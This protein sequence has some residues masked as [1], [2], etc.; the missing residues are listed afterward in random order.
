MRRVP[1]FLFPLLFVLPFAV[2]LAACDCNDG[3]TPTGACETS[4]DCED[5]QICVDMMCEAAPDGSTDTGTTDGGMDTGMPPC[6][7]DTDCGGGVC[8]GGS[9][10]PS[11]DLVCGSG[12][13][14]SGETCFANACVMPGGS[15]RSSEDCGD[16]QYCE[17]GLADPPMMGMDGGTPDAGMGD[18]GVCLGGA[19]TVGRCLDIPPR[20]A[21]GMPPGP[22]EVC[23]RD[24]EYR[25]P[26]GM[27]DAV[28]QWAF[29]STT[30]ETYTGR[31][32]V[33]STPTVGRVADTNC[34]GVVDEFDPPNVIFI[35]GNANGSY[36]SSSVNTNACK[37]GVIRALDGP[38]G[39]EL[40]SLRRPVMSSLG[41]AALS[42][43]IGDLD[44]DGDMEVVAID[45]EGYFNIVDHTGAHVA[46]SDSPIPAFASNNGTGWGGAVTIGDMDQDGNPELAYGRA[47][48]TTDGTSIT[49]L[50]EGA[51]DWGRGINQA[52]SVFVN[53][54]AD[55]ELELLSGRTAFNPDSSIHFDRAGVGSGFS[56]TGDFDGDGAP[57][58]PYVSG[59]R[60]YLLSATDGSDVMTSIAATGASP[61]NGGPPTVADFDG[62]GRPEIGVAF[63]ENYQ[64]VRANYTTMQLETV[65]SSP[66]HDLSSSVT[67]S[68]VFDFE[69][70]GAAEVIYN[71]ECF[72]WVY[73]GATGAVRFAT[74]TTS[75]TATE[76]SLVAD[77]DSDGS[78]EIVM[79]ANGADP[80]SSGWGC[81]VAPWT[82]P[83]AMGAPDFGRPAWVGSDGAS[84]AYR[85]L[86]VFRA[87]DNSWVGTR[88][89]WNQ[90]AYSVSNICGDRGDAC[91]PASTYGDIPMTQVDNWSVGFLNNF[92]QNIQ[93]EGIFDAPDATVTLAVVCENPLRLDAAVRNLGAAVLAEG[94]EVGFF[95]VMGGTEMEIGRATTTTALFPGQTA[96]VS[97][98]AVGYDETNTF[99]A[100]ILVDPAMPTFQECDDTNNESAEVMAR[101]LM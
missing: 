60:I 14:A 7:D 12:C 41:F 87:R 72:L 55:P 15:C 92:R 85:G 20:C 68:T 37:T 1:P 57:E 5:G 71:D 94:V 32:D 80:S 66:N 95:V 42:P 10:C 4:A 96:V 97:Y 51:G 2:A 40:W 17:T 69:G 61:G 75:F 63:R 67:G 46:R 65:W 35:S 83:A 82:S 21:D 101:C 45:G 79:V 6:V 9:C 73:D 81:D 62:D 99:K 89:L 31:L 90:H 39:R 49:F 29:D 50:W 24:C 8:V 70:D 11:V 58:I 64:V 84:Q 54:D 27:L 33:W 30:A 98:A 59:G 23:I 78:A 16:D 25:P 88:S 91:S 22:G 47:V 86:K 48:Y 100:R 77:V 76:A 43:A 44:H 13:C 38:T 53:L 26:V 18:A 93:G 74:P 56:A 52:I 3:K 28:E 19:P 36:C 34:D